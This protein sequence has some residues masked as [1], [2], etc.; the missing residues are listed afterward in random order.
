MPLCKPVFVNNYKKQWKNASLNFKIVRNFCLVLICSDICD[1]IALIVLQS[2]FEV[3]KMELNQ[4][5]L[6]ELSLDFVKNIMPK[7]PAVYTVVYVF[8]LSFEDGTDIK[9]V[10]DLLN[11]SETDVRAAFMYW[12]DRGLIS[13]NGENIEILKGGVKEIKNTAPQSSKS[14]KRYIVNDKQ[15][16]Y[17]P[18][19]LDMYADKNADVKALFEMAQS[20]LK[21]MLSYNDLSSVFSLYHWLGLKMEVI[22]LLLDFCVERGHRN[23]RY[24]ERVAIDWCEN[25]LNTVEAA[26]E[27]I[28]A[29]NGDYRQIMKAMGQSS[30]EPVQSEIDYIKKWTDVYK[31]PLDI[32]ELACTRTVMTIGKPS[33]NYADKILQSWHKAGVKTLS[34]VENTDR[35]YAENKKQTQ[36]TDQ[37]QKQNVSRANN[38]FT[39]YSQREYDYSEIER[40]EIQRLKAE[41]KN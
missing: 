8:A 39:N 21:R 32:I 29:Y 34:D 22:G 40:L 26:E 19:E 18:E 6:V 41:G 30:R 1:K 33:F 27:R 25:G 14:Q 28:N 23:M 20:K 24:I 3:V 4:N 7:A 31:M 9:T 36:N 12:Q 13:I 11:M 5:K 2:V 17:A 16:H 10:A 35:I 38:K 37:A 15:P